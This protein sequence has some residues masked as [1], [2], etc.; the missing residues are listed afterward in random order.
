MGFCVLLCAGLSF[1]PF[2]ARFHRCPVGA[3][4]TQQRYALPENLNNVRKGAN[5]DDGSASGFSSDEDSQN[6]FMNSDDD[7]D[8]VMC[9]N[10]DT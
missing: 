4:S 8:E 3:F 10:M 5:G 1:F 2:I 9:Q 6:S 7:D